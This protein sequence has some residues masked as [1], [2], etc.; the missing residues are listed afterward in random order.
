[1][2][3]YHA[4]A[5]KAKE[6]KKNREKQVE[7]REREGRRQNKMNAK[8]QDLSQRRLRKECK[9]VLQQMGFL[10][11]QQMSQNLLKTQ[12]PAHVENSHSTETFTNAKMQAVED[13]GQVVS[14]AEFCAALNAVLE[15]S[16]IAGFS[17]PFVALLPLVLCV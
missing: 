16:S 15:T 5:E 3:D 9:H 1:M 12:K 17:S 4:E 6:R 13:D 2:N 8:S 7:S 10:V 11:P 14:F